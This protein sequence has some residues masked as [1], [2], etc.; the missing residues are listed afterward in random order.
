MTYQR[1]IKLVSEV[2]TIVLPFQF[3]NNWIN[4][5]VRKKNIWR[6]ILSNE[7]HILKILEPN[8]ISIYNNIKNHVIFLNEFNLYKINMFKNEPKCIR[9]SVVD[10]QD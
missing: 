5:E 10:A 6:P 8:W 9:L 3:G 2:W 1:A 4:L 7:L